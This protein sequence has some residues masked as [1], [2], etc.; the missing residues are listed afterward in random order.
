MVSYKLIKIIL[1]SGK[2]FEI[3]GLKVSSK[4]TSEIKEIIATKNKLK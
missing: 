4:I 1:I 3:S 2:K